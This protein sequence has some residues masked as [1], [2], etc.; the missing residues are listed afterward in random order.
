M[1]Q[2]PPQFTSDPTSCLAVG[3]L[4]IA[5]SPLPGY[6][7]PQQDQQ[8]QQP[9]TSAAGLPFS[10]TAGFM[11]PISVEDESQ[12]VELQ[13]CWGALLLTLIRLLETATRRIIHKAYLSHHLGLH[14]RAVLADSG[15]RFFVLRWLLLGSGVRCFFLG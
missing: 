2:S 14:L 8:Q 10:T 7:L 15:G 6:P 11:Q 3:S 1:M 12:Q 5:A 9:P 13:P 4:S